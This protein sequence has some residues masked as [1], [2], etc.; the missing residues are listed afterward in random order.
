MV[1]GYRLED[2]LKCDKFNLD[3]KPNMTSKK[4]RELFLEH[5]KN[6]NGRKDMRL[7]QNKENLTNYYKAYYANLAGINED[8]D[9]F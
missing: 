4:N 2:L 9:S 8:E 3:G 6:I 7:K 5:G 1:N